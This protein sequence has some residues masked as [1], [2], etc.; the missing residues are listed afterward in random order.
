M[1]LFVPVSESGLAKL[2]EHKWTLQL[3]IA[4]KS[5]HWIIHDNTV[6]W[7]TIGLKRK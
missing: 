2:T 5:V 4:E 1:D 6:K 3:K 7:M